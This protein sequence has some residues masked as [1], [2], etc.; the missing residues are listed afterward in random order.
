[1]SCHH[2]AL[3][4]QRCRSSVSIHGW[5]KKAQSVR[6]PARKSGV[7]RDHDAEQIL[8]PSTRTRT[9]PRPPVETSRDETATSPAAP[10]TSPEEGIRVLPPRET[11]TELIS[12]RALLS[13]RSCRRLPG[14][15]PRRAR[16]RNE[17]CAPAERL[18]K[19]VAAD[20][21][22]VGGGR[23]SCCPRCR[24]SSAAPRARSTPDYR[25]PVARRHTASRRVMMGPIDEGSAELAG[26]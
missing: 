8:H 9:R 16:E 14:R 21:R 4:A 25:G 22:R 19:L 26:P 11:D 15:P 17:T 5:D 6:P 3:L 18:E 2:P 23:S 20:G 10:A 24:G 7:H 12:R 1:V 13:S